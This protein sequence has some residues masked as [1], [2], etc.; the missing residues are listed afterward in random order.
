LIKDDVELALASFE[1][2]IQ[3]TDVRVEPGDDPALALIAIAYVH[4]ADGRA[5]NLVYPFYLA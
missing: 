5:D 4:L 3:T 1:P 2:R